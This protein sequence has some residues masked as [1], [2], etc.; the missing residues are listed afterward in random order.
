M[1]GAYTIGISKFGEVSV[2]SE[3]PLH[4]NGIPH[5]HIAKD[6]GPCFGNATDAIT[7]AAA[8][9]K[10][11]DAIFFILRWLKHGYTPEL[12][13]VKIEEWPRDLSTKREVAH[14]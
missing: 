14:A 5:P 3:R 7:K 9:H 13:A 10:Y 6:G 12:T 2:W 4:P 11:Y 8:N 1:V